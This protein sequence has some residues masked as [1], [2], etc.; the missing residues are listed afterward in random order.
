MIC[1]WLATD[2][3]TRWQID[4]L[5]EPICYEGGLP[6]MGDAGDYRTMAAAAGFPGGDQRY[7]KIT[8]ERRHAESAPVRTAGG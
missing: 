4:H 7:L 6:S 2:R 5:L 3:P 8:C 1:A